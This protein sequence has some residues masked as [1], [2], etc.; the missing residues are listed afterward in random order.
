MRRTLLSM[1]VFGIAS[2]VKIT[3]D[4]DPRA[5]YSS[6][7]VRDFIEKRLQILLDRWVVVGY[8]VLLITGAIYFLE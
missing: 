1:P 5:M 6:L 4:D 3:Y 8:Q 7:Q 2:D